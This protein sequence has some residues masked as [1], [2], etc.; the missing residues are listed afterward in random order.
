MALGRRS[1]CRTSLTL[2]PARLSEIDNEKNAIPNDMANR[3]WRLTASTGANTG[4]SQ[5]LIPSNQPAP[6]HAPRFP[7]LRASVCF[8]T[9]SWPPGCCAPGWRGARLRP[10][11]SAS[12]VPHRPRPARVRKPRTPGREPE[13]SPALDRLSFHPRLRSA[14]HRTPRTA[15]RFCFRL[16]SHHLPIGTL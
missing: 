8:R 11:T 1:T 2:T 10:A 14:G 15:F 9:R 7:C 13:S 6:N 4:R 5:A 12:V 16:A 3:G